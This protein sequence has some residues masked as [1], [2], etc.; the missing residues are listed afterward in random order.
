MIDPGT[1]GTHFCLLYSIDAFGYF[2]CVLFG[3]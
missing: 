2:F 3:L 1:G